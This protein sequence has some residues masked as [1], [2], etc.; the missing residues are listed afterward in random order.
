MARLGDAFAKAEQQGVNSNS[1][2]I[3]RLLVPTG[4]RRNEIASLRWEHV[5]FERKALRLPDSKTGAKIVPLGAP[6]L[7]VLT[8]MPRKEGS[9]WVFPAARGKGH[10]GGMPGVWRKL[11]AAGCRMPESCPDAR[12]SPWL[13]FRRRG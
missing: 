3:L 7:A 6:A 5:D 13:C 12:P 2:A 11:R 8:A 4:A 10:R 1:L 9:P